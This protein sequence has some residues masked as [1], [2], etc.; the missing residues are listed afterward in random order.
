MA[1]LIRSTFSIHAQE[2][3]MAS[4]NLFGRRLFCAAVFAILLLGSVISADGQMIRRVRKN[5]AGGIV[6]PYTVGD[7]HG[8]SWMVYQA[9]TMSMQ[10]NFP[11]YQQ[12]G[13]ITIAGQ[14]PNVQPAARL[15]DKTNELIMENMQVGQFI[16]SRRILFNSDEGY[17]RVIDIVKNPTGQE[18]QCSIQLTSYINF[19]VQSSQII[20]DPKKAS[21]NLAWVATTGGQGRTALDVYA[22]S[23]A[24]VYPVVENQQG[25]N[26][27]SATVN[28]AI[29]ANKEIAVAH[30]HM[31][32]NTQEQGIAWVKD[33]KLSK[34]FADVPREIRREI[35]NFRVNG[36]LLGDLEVLRGDAMDVVELRGGDKFNGTLGETSY[37]LDT[38]YGTVEV[39]V[40]KV[41]CII[42]SGQF[43]PRQL[44][45]TADGQI[46]GGHL[47]KQSIDLELSSGQKT[48]IPLAQIARVGY[49]RR[50]EEKEDQ[51]DEQQ[52][53][54]PYL[55]LSSGDRVGV[56]LAPTPIDVVTRYGSLKLTPDMISSI[57]FNSDDS[58]VHSIELTDG[59]RF[60]GLCTATEFSVKLNTGGKDQEVKFPVAALN[61]IVF[62][63]RSD[64]KDDNAPSLQLKK[65]DVVTG[66]LQGDLKLDTTFDTIALHAPEIRAI[67]HSKEGPADVSVTTWDG[68]VFSGQLQE[69]SIKCHLKSG[70]DMQIPVAL[71][72]T[73]S[74][75]SAT[76]P[77][78]MLEKIKSIVG[79]LNADDYKQ[80]DD[81]EQKLLRFGVGIIP[82]LKSM[83]D[84]QTPEGQQRIDSVL[85]QLQK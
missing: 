52:L 84:Q 48:Q 37:K 41:I 51:A 68:T 16:F 62:G 54:P 9:A 57:I 33:M 78:M 72:E 43:K 38:F 63:N 70:L 14:Q 71:M 2:I 34:L 13:T 66:T 8:Q 4:S 59:S 32:V 69:Q 35:V 5:A 53:Q 22:S 24:K 10:G 26:M 20:S 58:G 15:D 76:V 56:T 27:V 3:A 73:Y 18:L 40:E 45:V 60:N 28:I 1:G 42:N 6:L 25:N 44:I 12:A 81:A 75:P 80:R 29:P 55:L 21:Q 36:G 82:T 19:G 30:F 49:R 17:A 61:R 39:P 67:T 23:S 65:E 83:R 46:F 50:P 7:G 77:P 79:D 11:V 74:N 47:Q 64:D 31:V 85:K